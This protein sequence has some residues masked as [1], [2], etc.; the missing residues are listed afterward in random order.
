MLVEAER[1]CVG[2]G[3]F[4]TPLRPNSDIGWG[5]IP[6]RSSLLLGWCGQEDSNL[7]GSPH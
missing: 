3:P 2:E 6:Q 4:L 7:H 5:G 1:S